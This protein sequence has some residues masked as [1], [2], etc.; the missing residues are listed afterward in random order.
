MANNIGVFTILGMII[1]AS[2]GGGVGLIVG[3][4]IGLVI[5]NN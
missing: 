3:G 2:L 1:G 4:L 5:D